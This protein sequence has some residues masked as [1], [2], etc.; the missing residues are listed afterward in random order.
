[1]IRRSLL[2]VR[3]TVTPQ[4][5]N[6]AAWPRRQAPSTARP[7]RARRL[8][9]RGWAP[10]KGAPSRAGAHASSTTVAHSCSP[11][12]R[13]CHRRLRPRRS[14]ALRRVRV[15]WARARV[16]EPHARTSP[17][18]TRTLT[19]LRP[20]SGLARPPLARAASLP[21]SAPLPPVP[22]PMGAPPVPRAAVPL[23]PMPKREQA[24]AAGTCASARSPLA[25]LRRPGPATHPSPR[26]A[27]ACL[28]CLRWRLPLPRRRRRQGPVAAALCCP[29]TWRRAARL[30]P[31]HRRRQSRR[32]PRCP[33]SPAGPL[34]ET[35]RRRRPRSRRRLRRPRR[36]LPQLLR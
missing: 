18:P 1:M 11:L 20:Q 16:R 7:P 29:R 5:R 6:S 31:C 3:C 2:C 13:R 34:L 28:Q 22:P 30:R 19:A 15:A 26:L 10:R 36:G 14:S 9:F 25:E 33:N 35:R 32:H 24:G 23:P 4:T 17:V 12:A 8:G 27:P 21:A